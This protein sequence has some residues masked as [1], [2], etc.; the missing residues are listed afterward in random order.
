MIAQS[1]SSPQRWPSSFPL[2][3]WRCWLFNWLARREA[4]A[5]ARSLGLPVERVI[6]VDLSDDD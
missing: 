5:L 3:R 4:A 6:L 1:E 2:A